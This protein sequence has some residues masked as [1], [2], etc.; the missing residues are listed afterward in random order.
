M[1]GALMSSLAHTV[2]GGLLSLILPPSTM[3]QRSPAVL[4]ADNLLCVDCAVKPI[5]FL[6]C[7]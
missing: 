7:S 3:R 1:T 6:T 4:E 2:I 5:E